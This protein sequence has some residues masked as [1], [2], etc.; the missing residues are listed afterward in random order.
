VA[1]LGS[2]LDCHGAAAPS[3][4]YR[5]SKLKAFWVQSGNRGSRV[6]SAA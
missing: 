4:N 6:F 5:F 3:G 1:E 2:D